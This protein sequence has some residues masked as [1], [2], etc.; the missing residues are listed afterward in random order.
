MDQQYPDISDQSLPLRN[1]K[2]KIVHPN[3]KVAILVLCTIFLLPRNVLADCPHGTAEQA[4]AMVYRAVEL[5]ETVG[6]E[7]ALPVFMNPD[8][9]YIKGNLY[10]FAMDF[11][12]NIVV[13]NLY[14]LSAGENIL[15]LR[16]LDGRY[17]IKEM[18]NL[19]QAQGEGW[20][21][22]DF[23]DPCTGRVSS[24]STFVKRVNNILIGVGYY[25]VV[26][27]IRPI[28][29]DEPHPLS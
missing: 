11:S 20:V 24:K 25:G 13:N 21:Q 16:T 9:G 29:K 26:L 28:F 3:L 18:I 6:T 1:T 15:N 2:M 8:N 17:F 14:P 19:A 4:K 5:V 10:L 22:Y 23:G 7:S 12:G 27:A